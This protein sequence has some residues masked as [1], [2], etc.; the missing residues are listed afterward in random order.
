MEIRHIFPVGCFVSCA[1]CF[2]SLSLRAQ[3]TGAFFPSP[4]KAARP[5]KH[6]SAHP[7]DFHQKPDTQTN[8]QAHQRI[9]P[10]KR[11]ADTQGTKKRLPPKPD[12]TRHRAVPAAAVA[13]GPPP[14]ATITP[15]PAVALPTFA[16][17]AYRD[18]RSFSEYL[19]THNSLLAHT[20]K[21]Q[22]DIA[23]IRPGAADLLSANTVLFYA[24]TGVLFFLAVIRITFSKYFSDLFRAF[25]NP[26]LSQRQLREQ[27]S[28]T[29]F[30]ALLLNLFFT[31]SAG[32]YLF[33]ILRHFQYI[34]VRQPLVLI[35][36]FMGLIMVVYLVKYAFLRLTGWLFN[37]PEVTTGY[38]FTLYMVNKVLGVALIPFI[39]VLAF[40]APEIASV[41][42][43][44]SVVL[45]ILLFVYR[46]IR[47]YAL[48]K[49]Q[50]FFNKF[51]FF[52]YLCGF[53]IAP[54]LI[55]G[56]L[57]LLWLNGA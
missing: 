28:Q 48:V 5:V 24:I 53:E 3:D 9:T 22:P 18:F 34:T 56:K 10:V 39:L 57:V 31:L 17:T 15:F 20:E 8:T 33:L 35:P 13:S 51:Q 1:L 36:V 49:N 32:L 21:P 37:Y 30:P 2:M 41:A 46:Y 23:E 27:L 50:I 6:D 54:V 26:T 55:I 16:D 40:S 45:I 43:S 14:P 12:T 52:V 47:S 38:V 44:I 7:A 42:L 19:L 11:V 4:H 25:F 29:P